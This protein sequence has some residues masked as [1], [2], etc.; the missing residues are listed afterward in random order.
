MGKKEQ[1]DSIS[2]Q[3]CIITSGIFTIKTKHC[4]RNTNKKTCSSACALPLGALEI[5]SHRE[6]KSDC[7]RVPHP[8]WPSSLPCLSRSRQQHYITVVVVVTASDNMHRTSHV[9]VHGTAWPKNL[10]LCSVPKNGIEVWESSEK[11]ANFQ[12]S[13]SWNTL[14]H[15]TGI[16]SSSYHHTFSWHA[17]WWVPLSYPWP[18]ILRTELW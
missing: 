3:Y 10:R 16:V 18:L 13:M 1:T 15:N 9:R 6:G 14:I 4:A 2:E 7:S 12:H 17:I 8:W 11:D 5:T